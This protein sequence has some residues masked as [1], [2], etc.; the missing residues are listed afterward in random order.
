MFSVV[1]GMT[2]SMII[3]E[4]DRRKQKK[5]DMIV[6]FIEKDQDLN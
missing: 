4:V 6:P 2:I 3:A 1:F 5:V